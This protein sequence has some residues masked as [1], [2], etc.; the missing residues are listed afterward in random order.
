MQKTGTSGDE[1]ERPVEAQYE[2]DDDAEIVDPLLVE[3]QPLAQE[4]VRKVA[5]KR[6]RQTNK[7]SEQRASMRVDANTD[8]DPSPSRRPS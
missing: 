5:W 2:I 8:R 3:H 7:R 1:R 4:L 6:A